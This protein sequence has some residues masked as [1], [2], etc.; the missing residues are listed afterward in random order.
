MKAVK[1]LLLSER[2]PFVVLLLL[3]D[4]TDGSRFV[5]P[6]RTAGRSQMSFPHA[7]APCPGEILSWPRAGLLA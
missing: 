1:V 3:P 4:R 6:E 7:D 5:N 2:S